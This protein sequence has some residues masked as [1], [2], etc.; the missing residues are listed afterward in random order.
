MLK[1]KRQHGQVAKSDERQTRLYAGPEKTS[2]Q[3]Y[4]CKVRKRCQKVYNLVLQWKT[5]RCVER[6]MVKS[7]KDHRGSTKK[8]AQARGESESK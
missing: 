6:N 1:K 2:G 3:W 4:V 7:V 5:E 8:K